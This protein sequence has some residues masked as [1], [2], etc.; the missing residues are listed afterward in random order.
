V[1]N[2]VLSQSNAA[3]SIHLVHYFPS[4]DAIL[5]MQKIKVVQSAFAEY[6]EVN[7]FTR[8]YA[9]LQQTPVK[10]F[11]KRDILIASL[12]DINTTDHIYS[13]VDFKNST[14]IA[15]RFGGEGDGWQTIN[16]YN[17]KLDTWYNVVQRAWKANGKLYIATFIE[18]LSTGE[19]FHTAT[20]SIPDP[21]KYLSGPNDAFLENWDGDSRKC[22]G[23]HVRSAFF[24]DAWN[25]NP[26]G[27]WEKSTKV[28]F[29]ANAGEADV[30][31]NGIYHN[32]FNAFYDLT[33]NAYCLRHGGTTTPSPEFKGERK[34]NLPA[35]LDQGTSPKL[36][37]GAITSVKANYSRGQVNVSW[38]TDKIKSPQLS[39][40]IEIADLKGTTV[41]SK[42]DTSP[43][44][45]NIS[46][47][48][49]LAKGKYIVKMTIM[50]IFNEASSPAL[51]DL[52]VLDD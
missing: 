15:R 6:F 27:T 46:I 39:F 34:I 25:L 37:P 22:D 10:S 7:S 8:G 12:W 23:R 29:S 35:Q 32:S 19:W 33:E 42:Q 1:N 28:V 45:R 43:E 18:D 40:F 50:D 2:D 26:D 5:K 20:F 30:R 51:T 44:K 9:G 24:K 41:I 17:W 3:P 13:T 4:N 49:H 16:P 47:P 14:T 38:E 52:W 11:G 21:G 36:A 31:R 48:A